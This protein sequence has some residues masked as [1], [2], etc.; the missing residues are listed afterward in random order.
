MLK[1]MN[2]SEKEKEI[3]AFW[4]DN[5]VFKKSIEQHPQDAGFV[6]YD[7]PPFATGLPHYGHLVTGVMKDVV[8]RFWT[9]KGKRVERKWGWDCHGLPIENLVEKEL[10]LNSKKDIEAL[11]VQKFNTACHSKVMMYADEWKKVVERLGRFVDMDE[12]Y[13]TMDKDFMESVWWVFSELWKKD[14]IYEDHKPMHICPRCETTLAHAEVTEGYQTVKDLA[15]TA[16]FKLRDEDNTSILAWTTTPWTLPGNVALAVGEDIPYIKVSFEG[17]YYIV[18]VPLLG[19]VFKDKEYKEVERLSA[20]DLVGKKYEP[21]FDYFSADESLENRENAFTIIAADFV[22]TDTGT[23]IVHIAPGFGED[24][25]N[26]GKKHKLPFVQHV[27]TDGRFTKVVTDWPGIEVK[28]KDDPT[29]TDVLIIKYLAGKDLLFSKEKYEHTYPHCWRC[30]SPLLNY[31]TSAWFVKVTAIKDRA[32]ELADQINWVPSH[33]KAGRFGQWLEGA[34]DWSISRQRYW[35]SVMPLWRCECSKIKVFGSIEDLEK[36]SGKKVEDLHKHVVDEI[37]VPCACGKEMRRIPDVLDCWFESGSMPYA[38][39]HYPFENK[40][41]FEQNFPAEFIAEGADQTSKWFYYLH[42][43][44]VALFDSPAYKNVIVNGIVLAEDGKK[45]SKRLQ[46]YP[47]PMEVMEKYGSDALRFYLMSSPV[48]RA[49]NL[50]FDKKGVDEVYKKVIMITENIMAF[51]ALHSETVIPSEVEGSRQTNSV[52][53]NW[54][55]ARLHQMNAAVSSAYEHY[56]LQSACRPILNFVQDFSTWYVRRSRDRMKTDEKTVVIQTMGQVMEVLSKVMAPVTPFLAERMYQAVASRESVHLADWPQAGEIDKEA[57]ENMTR[58]RHLVERGLAQ[59]AAEGIKVRQPLASFTHDDKELDAAYHFLLEDELNVKEV[60]AGDV[61]FLD[62]HLTDELKKEGLAREIT[63]Q[64]NSARKK[65][66]LT[67][68]DVIPIYIELPEQ[69]AVVAKE[70]SEQIAKDTNATEIKLERPDV[71]GYD[72]E[73]E[74]EKAWV[75][76]GG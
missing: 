63:R 59:R 19:E 48:V 12:D 18:A 38:Q 75:A 56:D 65:A 53:D 8:P 51:Y 42:V 73:I 33:I 2:I 25:F 3:I 14:L 17:A 9:M 27:G 45:M 44:A 54:I 58:V 60:K 55:L 28:P 34:R 31:T 10:G 62:T 40:E 4:K 1:A 16:K 57:L 11:G 36:E 20:D 74:K 67:I 7:G 46:N 13:K 41:L 76:F 35:G 68:K 23:G 21:L 26:A 64:I 72:V 43:L 5:D 47:D 70:F 69:L 61:L 52:L 15:V 6:F 22:T 37:T 29:S 71:I 24:D 32:I 49:E 30:D 66:G 50:S 39:L